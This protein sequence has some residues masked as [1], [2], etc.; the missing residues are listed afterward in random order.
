MASQIA[1]VGLGQMGQGISGNL[2]AKGK[3]EKPLLLWNRTTERAAGHSTK[4][5]HCEH[6]ESLIKLTQ[7]SNVIWICLQDEKALQH[8]LD[9]MLEQ[10]VQGKLFVDS[11]TISP[12]FT[13]AVAE[14][15][16]NSG[17]EFVAAP[18]FG[19]PSMA[20]AATLTV[21]PAG[22]EESVNRILPYLEGVIGRAVVNLSGE[23]PGQ[24]SLLKFIGNVMIMTSMETAAEMCTFAEKTKLGPSNILKLFEALMP[25]SPHVVTGA[26]QALALAGK[27]M[28]VAKATGTSLKSYEV[29]VQHLKDAKK[30][31]GPDTSLLGIYGAIRQESGLPYDNQ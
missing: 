18:V 3:L 25:T 23:Q 21:I 4:F 26:S 27:V 8:V 13:N 14:R 1:F 29:A 12:N 10:N 24:A 30:L 22:K 31:A 9:E 28:G 20:K 7:E 6:V 5:E 2:I 16:I 19:D 11:S 17:A 15:V